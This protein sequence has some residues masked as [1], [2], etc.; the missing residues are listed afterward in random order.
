MQNFE[1]TSS[2]YWGQC[3]DKTWLT[4]YHLHD[5]PK[6]HTKFDSYQFGSFSNSIKIDTDNRQWTTDKQADVKRDVLFVF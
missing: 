5:I 3:L 4:V 2:N 1:V 6:I